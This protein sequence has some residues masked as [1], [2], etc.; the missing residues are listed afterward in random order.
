MLLP[1]NAAQL[2]IPAVLPKVRALKL[3]MHLLVMKTG[4]S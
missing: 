2:A 4:E 1:A 3:A